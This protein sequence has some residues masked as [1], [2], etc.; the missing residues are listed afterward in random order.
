MREL[1]SI[2]LRFSATISDTFS[3]P[4]YYNTKCADTITGHVV[5]SSDSNDLC[6]DCN[7]LCR[8]YFRTVP[9]TDAGRYNVQSLYI[10]TEPD[11]TA[12]FEVYY[13]NIVVEILQQQ[14]MHKRY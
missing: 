10:Y 1:R 14:S 8:I 5:S 11:K 7:K 13:N 3:G 4:V 9:A 6:S 12:S 2:V